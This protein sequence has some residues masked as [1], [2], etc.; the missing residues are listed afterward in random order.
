MALARGEQ[1]AAAK[2]PE[3]A[4]QRKSVEWRPEAPVR[5]LWL[6]WALRT[7]F[8]Q[9]PA[10]QSGKYNLAG[11]DWFGEMMWM[12]ARRDPQN[13]NALVLAAKGGHNQEMH[14]QNDVGSF[15]VWTN[16]EAII[17]D[18]GRG[19]YTVHF[20]P[21]RY[22]HFVNSS[23]GHSVPIVN[24]YVQ[25][26]GREHTA[27][28]IEHSA[29]PAADILTI[30][31]KQAYP[32]EARLESLKRMVALHREGKAG[33]VE[34]RDDV[35]FTGKP[36]MLQSV[37]TTFAAVNIGP[38][39]VTLTGEH[40]TVNVSFDPEVSS[41]RSP[42]KRTSTFRRVSTMSTWSCSHCCSRRSRTARLRVDVL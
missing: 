38:S 10:G 11:H 21:Q 2:A 30:E 39:A 9:P 12:V 13:A 6:P 26:A 4:S 14:N 7:L 29:G 41:L 16:G 27:K 25:G 17:P 42:S 23:H 1:M 40:A 8:W 31:M 5:E 37:L 22:E 36:G 35:S 28:L 19:R 34:V 32:P 3:L 18:I 20:G 24:G 33:W 15:I